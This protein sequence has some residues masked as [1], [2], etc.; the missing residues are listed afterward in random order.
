MKLFFSI[1]LLVAA[2][3]ASCSPT[4]LKM[5]QLPTSSPALA[6]LP[7][8]W[9][10]IW[11]DEFDAPAGSPPD[12]AKW[13]FDLGGE[14][15]GNQEWEY[16]TD[17]PENAA[18]DG[19]G[20][21]VI[22]AIEVAEDDTRSLNCW[23]GP[24]KYTSARILTRERFDFTYGRVEARLKLPYGNGIWPAFWMLGSDI[25]A[26]GWPNCGEIDIMENIG[27]EPDKVYGTVHGPGYSGA[28]GI[29]HSYALP[30]GQ[31]FKDD[32]HVFALEWDA[33]E[34]RWYMDDELYGVLPKERFSESRPWVFDHPFFL[35]LNVAV[36]GAWPGYP[37]ETST[38]PQEMLVDYV[39]VYQK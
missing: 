19:A 7:G 35:I 8:G 34:I 22:R 10:L 16:Y 20:S 26:V 38:F 32:F 21:L 5:P 11:N 24:C 13:T 12:P 2:I 18:T 14:G 23:Y 36:G 37:D 31:A 27:R 29:S 33:V 6:E 3:M 15:W 17:Q 25:A 1:S 39:R 30:V 9:K 28:N 4:G